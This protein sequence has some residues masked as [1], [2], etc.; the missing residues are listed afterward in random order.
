MMSLCH[1]AWFAKWEL[2]L[3]N[4]LHYIMYMATSYKLGNIVPWIAEYSQQWVLSNL[5]K[6]HSIHI[7]H[8]TDGLSPQNVQ[9]MDFCPG[10]TGPIDATVDYAM[11]GTKDISS[12]LFYHMLQGISIVMYQSS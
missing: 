2:Y 8:Q 12:Y 7:V 4:T 9:V 5:I 11:S 6:H 3:D 1:I 10:I